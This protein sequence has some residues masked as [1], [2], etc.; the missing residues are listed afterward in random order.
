MGMVCRPSRPPI[1]IFCRAEGPSIIARGIVNVHYTRPLG[2]PTP[3][4]TAKHAK[5]AATVLDERG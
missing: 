4:P 2:H 5:F 1:E 3:P